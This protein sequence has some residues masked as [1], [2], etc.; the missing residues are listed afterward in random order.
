MITMRFRNILLACLAT[1]LYEIIGVGAF[2]AQNKDL[3]DPVLQSIGLKDRDLEFKGDSMLIRLDQRLKEASLV[4]G[5]F[6][7]NAIHTA[8]AIIFTYEGQ[9]SRSLGLLHDVLIAFESTKDIAGQAYVH[10]WMSSDYKM[11]EQFAIAE[12][13]AHRSFELFTQAHQPKGMA[14]AANAL[15]NALSKQGKIEEALVAY[16][17]SKTISDEAHYAIGLSRAFNNI[18]NLNREKGQME[19]ALQNYQR[20]LAI[21]DSAKEEGPAFYLNNIGGIYLEMGKAEEGLTF[22]QMAR[23]TAGPTPNFS[24]QINVYGNL[25]RAYAAIADFENAYKAKDTLLILNNNMFNAR[26]FAL[27]A[28]KEA[29]Y[30]KEKDVQKIELLSK[31][32][33]LKELEISHGSDRNRLLIVLVITLLLIGAL[34]WMAYRNKRQ[35]NKLL[36]LQNN[37]IELMN[38]LLEE[39]VQQ[40]TN[41]LIRVNN[42]LDQLLYRS[43]HDLRTPITKL[44]GLLSLVVDEKDPVQLAKYL[45]MLDVSVQQLD[46]LNLSICEA[47]NIRIHAPKLENL[48]LRALVTELVATS[49]SETLQWQM[50]T[51]M[52]VHADKWLLSLALEELIQNA[53]DAVGGK[54]CLVTLEC[55]TDAQTQTIQ[56]SDNGP[57]VPESMHERLFDLF[58]KGNNAAGHHGLGLYKARLAVERLG[59]SLHLVNAAQSGA[60]FVITLQAPVFSSER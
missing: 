2:F 14:D 21:A 49:F 60:T 23:S 46:K 6:E 53:L 18:A 5:S 11:L 10:R 45:S 29:L 20:A 56:V 15:G 4:K 34:G 43:S 37:R 47:G 59:G 52:V 30:Q 31:D 13:H 41:D 27:I 57:G 55:K 54:Q 7:E 39:K 3:A 42:E 28:E 8:E 26:N 51:D 12:K 50:P 38:A 17:Q 33:L 22:I 36:S 58:S 24:L 40:R 9:Y 16:E 32:N 25:A 35:S 19:L 48:H 1:L 44:K